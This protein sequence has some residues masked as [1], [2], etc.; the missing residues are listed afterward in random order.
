MGAIDYLLG[1]G[2]KVI[3]TDDEAVELTL[4]I[5]S[6]RIDR[7]EVVEW[8]AKDGRLAACYSRHSLF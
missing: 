7:D 8:L 1:A 3:A 5:E 2:L 4:G 6:K